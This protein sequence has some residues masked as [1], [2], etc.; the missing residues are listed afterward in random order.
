MTL[1]ELQARMGQTGT[2]AL[3]NLDVL[4]WV[5]DAKISYG[6]PRYQ[7]APVAGDG[8]AWV[9]ARRVRFPEP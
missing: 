5:T 1:A 4:V 2:I 6:E 9:A 7:V 3:D 8:T